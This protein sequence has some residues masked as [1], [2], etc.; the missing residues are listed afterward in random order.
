M[1]IQIQDKGRITL[2][3]KIRKVLGI[4]EKDWVI[5]VVQGNKIVIKPK[6]SITVAQTFGIIKSKKRI[7]LEDIEEADGRDALS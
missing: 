6:N 3:S 1:E 4:K 7:K 5:I 2:P